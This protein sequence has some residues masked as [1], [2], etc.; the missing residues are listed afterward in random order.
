LKE[1]GVAAPL[2]LDFMVPNGPENRAVAEVVQSM[3]AEAGFDLKI[4]VTEFATSLK[5][6][7]DG[8]YQLYLI[9]WSGRSDPDGNSFVFQTCNA[10]QNNGKYCDKEVDAA[11]AV[12]RAKSDPAERKKAYEIVAKKVLADGSILYLYHVQVLVALTDK[13]EGYKQM[14]DGLVRVVGVKLK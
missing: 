12:A 3:A 8:D 11:H 14:P 2:T 5:Q 10:P 7:E 6:G 4:R 1:A 9:G 13:V